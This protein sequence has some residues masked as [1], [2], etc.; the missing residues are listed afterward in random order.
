MKSSV[1]RQFWGSTLM[2]KELIKKRVRFD[3]MKLIERVEGG[4]R[5][6]GG[7]KKLFSPNSI[8]KPF[9]EH[10]FWGIPKEKLEQRRQ[11][12]TILMEYLEKIFAS[13]DTN[14][15]SFPIT[16]KQKKD[17]H[18]LFNWFIKNNVK[19]LAIEKP[20][21]NGIV[22]GIIDCIAILDGEYC[23]LEIKLRNNLQVNNLD[24]FQAS[25]YAYLMEIPAYVLC[26]A[27]NGDIR[28]EKIYK[29]TCH[30][31]MKKIIEIYKTFGVE[32]DFKQRLSI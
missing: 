12:G 18:N 26:L 23:I 8:L 31:E 25:I 2:S 27:D 15:N 29:Q 21:T 10:L 9:K 7:S 24:R 13:K 20:I 4:H 3:Y 32:L 16:V 6:I 28:F 19:L 30:K 22:Y 11:D 17:L 1:E 14:I 5:M